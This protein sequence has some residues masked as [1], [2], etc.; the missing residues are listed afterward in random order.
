MMSILFLILSILSFAAAIAI[1]VM[2]VPASQGIDI[3]G[4]YIFFTLKM[5]FQDLP[6]TES[7]VNSWL[8][9]LG[10]MFLCMFMTSGLKTRNLSVRQ[11]LAE[12]IV[13]KTTNLVKSNMGEFFEGFAPFVAAILQ[14]LFTDRTFPS[15][16]RYQYCRRLGIAGFFPDHIL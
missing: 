8:I 1:K 3:A 14:S 9:I 15:D 12:W 6:I 10:I 13:E 5:P 2:F 4:A 11:L 16:I 7:Q